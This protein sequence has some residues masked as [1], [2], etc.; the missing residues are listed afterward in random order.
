MQGAIIY[1]VCLFMCLSVCVCVTFVDFADCESCTRPISTNLGYME[2]GE[3]GPTRG[4]CFAA[5]LL[6][7]VAVAGLLWNSW[8]VLGAAGF[9][10]LFPVFFFLLLSRRASFTP[11]LVIPVAPVGYRVRQC[12]SHPWDDFSK[13]D[14][15]TTKRLPM[16]NDT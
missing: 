8:C 1:L 10:V 13:L 9:R 11:P 5:R 16:P 6:E 7:V 15:S 3:Y 14:C 4:T 12:I 2:A